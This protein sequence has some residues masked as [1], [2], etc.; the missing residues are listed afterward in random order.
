MLRLLIDGGNAPLKGGIGVYTYSLLDAFRKYGPD[1]IEA[2]D[3]NVSWPAV[4]LRPARRLIY[5]M[6][7]SRLRSKG[8]SGADV[9]HFT[10]YY[11]PRAVSNTEYVSS[12]HDLDPIMLPDTYTRRYRIYFE[13]TV[14]RAVKHSRI[15]I[16]QTNAVRDE[17]LNWAGVDD[18]HVRVGGDGLS[19]EFTELATSTEKSTPEFPTLLFVGQINKKKNCAWMVKTLSTGV[20]TGALP[21]LK[22]ILAG[23]KG[24]GFAETARELQ[25]AGP[26]AEWRPSPSFLEIIRLYC[27]CSAVVV[28]SLREGFGRI[29]LEGM[30]CTKPIVASRIPSSVEVAG[31]VPYYFS[32]GNKDEFYQAVRDS[33]EGR[34][35]KPKLLAIPQQLSKYSWETLVQNYAKIYR[36]ARCQN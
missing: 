21:P 5:L 36:D 20:K 4:T 19:T 24:Y 15:L 10:N 2:S 7:L 33:I 29:L 18:D 11:V 30:Y 31:D 28:P 23:K 22:L 8:F 12:I 25:S 32:L 14:K 26:I 17:L 9:V 1:D 35:N 16:T 13:I 34:N 27:S 3:A 6:K